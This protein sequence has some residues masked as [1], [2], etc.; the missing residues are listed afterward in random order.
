[1][2]ARAE[3]RGCAPISSASAHP[4]RDAPRIHPY[5]RAARYLL[6]R[7]K[8]RRGEREIPCRPETIPCA[9]QIIPC[10]PRREFACNYVNSHMFSRRILAKSGRFGEIPCLFPCN[11]GILPV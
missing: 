8:L 5:C 10:S 9:G 1:M 7:D 4:A 11:Q 6:I 2:A 3:H